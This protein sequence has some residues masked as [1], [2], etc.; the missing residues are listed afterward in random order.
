MLKPW[1]ISTTL[2]N[3]FRIVD[4]LRVLNENLAGSIWSR[5]TQ[6]LFQVHL[7]KN[8]M[9]GLESAEFKNGI[10]DNLY[11]KFS[12]VEE[13]FSLD[14]AWEIVKAKNYRDFPMRGRTSFSPLKEF[15][16]VR[17]NNEDC[18]ELTS[19]GKFVLDGGDYAEFLVKAFL[20]WQYNNPINSSFSSEEYRTKPF[21]STMHLINTVNTL[22][23]KEN[24]KVKGI[25]KLEFQL[26][27]LTLINFENINSTANDLINFRLKFAKCSNRDERNNLINQRIRV[28]ETEFKSLSDLKDYTDNAIRWFRCTK[29][30]TL[31][32]GDNYIDIEDR[33]KAEIEQIL[34]TYSG[35]IEDNLYYEENLCNI[36]YPKLPWETESQL[37]KIYSELC[38]D[39]EQYHQDEKFKNYL[40]ENENFDL[41]TRINNLRIFRNDLESSMIKEK[42]NDDLYVKNIVENFSNIRSLERPSVALE[43]I[44]L[45]SLRLINDEIDIKTNAPIGDDNRITFTA[46]GGVADI[47]CLYLSYAAIYEVTLLVGRN[48]WYNEGQPVMRHLRDFENK[49]SQKYNNIFCIFISPRLHEDTLNTFW[50]SNKYEYKGLKQKIIPFN[51]EQ[52]IKILKFIIERKNNNIEFKSEY[53]NNLFSKIYDAVNTSTTSSLWKESIDNLIEEW[54]LDF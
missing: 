37:Q 41:K 18:I 35:D 8:R 6:S 54:K 30:F 22:C 9:Y 32:G 2:R 4:F 31:R 34:N 46:P 3:P 27:A 51:F 14:D 11:Q 24:L 5:E 29:F 17:I 50:T 25:S 20:K 49:Y 16:L 43:E 40:I 44:T 1:S 48:Q 53:L 33:K 21:V 26:F 36:D 15:G 23:Q 38:K 13:E 19:S 10:P 52:F 45:N 47:E 42:Y 39:I 12:N 28:L 7:I